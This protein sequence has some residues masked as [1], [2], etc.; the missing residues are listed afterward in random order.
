MHVAPKRRFGHAQGQPM[1][2]IDPPGMN[3]LLQHTH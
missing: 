1:P 2:A 3:T